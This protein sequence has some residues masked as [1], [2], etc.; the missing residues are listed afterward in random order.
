MF[1]GLCLSA[2]LWMILA[3]LALAD[4]RLVLSGFLGFLFALGLMVWTAGER[5]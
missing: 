4:D 2:F 5:A 1:A 3:G